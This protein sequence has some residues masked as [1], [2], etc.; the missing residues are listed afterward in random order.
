MRYYSSV[1]SL[2]FLLVFS[3][4]SEGKAWYHQ[5]VDGKGLENKGDAISIDI[6]AYDSKAIVYIGD[7][8]LNIATKYKD[9]SNYYRETIDH[10]RYYYTSADVSY[11]KYGNLHVAYIA[12]CN[13]GRVNY[14]TFD[15]SKWIKEIVDDEHS[16]DN[17]D[18]ITDSYGV[19]HL[20][21]YDDTENNL[22]YATRTGSGSWQVSIVD[23]IGNVGSNSEIYVSDKDEPHIV[24]SDNDSECL[25]HA[26]IGKFGWQSTNLPNVESSSIH[27]EIYGA[28]EILDENTFTVSFNSSGDLLYA[29]YNG[30]SWEMETVSDIYPVTID[31][32]IDSQGRATIT[33]KDYNSSERYVATKTDTGWTE[34]LIEENCGAAAIATTSNDKSHIACMMWN[35][36]DYGYQ[37]RHIY[38]SGTQWTQKTVDH[39]PS[40]INTSFSGEI[41][42]DLDSSGVPHIGYPYQDFVG[43]ANWN[44]SVWKRIHVLVGEDNYEVEDVELIMEGEN[45]H[46]IASKFNSLYYLYKSKDASSFTSETIW[47]SSSFITYLSLQ[48]DSQNHPHLVFYD[49]SSED[50]L[51]YMYYDG[52]SWNITT[53]DTNGNVGAYAQLRLDSN[54]V[55]YVL[56]K[57]ED[58]VRLAFWGGS[59]WVIEDLPDTINLNAENN[60]VLDGL[61]RPVA[62][63]REEIGTPGNMEN[64]LTL[65]TKTDSGWI[66][67]RLPYYDPSYHH[68]QSLVFDDHGIPHVVFGDYCEGSETC[69]DQLI[70][71]NKN[72]GSWTFE[73]VKQS[74]YYRH[75]NNYSPYIQISSDDTVHI[76]Y[77]NTDYNEV[78]YSTR[79]L[80]TSEYAIS[81]TY[82]G[83]CAVSP[84]GSTTVQSGD[85]MTVYVLPAEGY[86]V[87]SVSLDDVEIGKRMQYTFRNIS[88]DHTLHITC[89]EDGAVSHR[90]NILMGPYLL[91]LN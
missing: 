2:G 13:G 69:E 15:G 54:D 48:L 75:F 22:R 24:Y 53:I 81:A 60:F 91:L 37:L 40:S 80:T 43:Y 73:T 28:I 5:V 33:F 86:K 12:D 62:L 20:S 29:K 47:N 1:V 42:M 44:G 65:I 26:Y 82:D 77:G 74:D 90:K 21:Y 23:A 84:S 25:K 11:D 64:S 88:A 46:M 17:V 55:P 38:G 51:R 4:I 71:G 58:N 70:Y 3:V 49:S 27:N 7:S 66:Y 79:N 39:D 45:V 35:Q 41:S 6:D 85:T 57:R 16:Y 19:P 9:D 8:S 87:D 36:S 18:I 32:T 76:A 61:Q 68:E 30:F 52:T 14:A 31:S 63:V 67:D 89:S 83:Q 56:Y 78:Q 72:D 50:D 59:G 34:K 10:C